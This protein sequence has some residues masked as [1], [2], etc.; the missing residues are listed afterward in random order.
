MKACNSV[1]MEPVTSEMD[2]A[3]MEK[4]KAEKV[5]LLLTSLEKKIRV[6]GIDSVGNQERDCKEDRTSQL[7]W[8]RQG[9][10]CI[11]FDPII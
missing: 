11:F 2:S 3:A 1:K 5:S 7:E 10:G 8:A 6:A 9:N 4:E